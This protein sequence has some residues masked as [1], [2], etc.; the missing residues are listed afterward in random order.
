MKGSHLLPVFVAATTACA[1]MGGLRTAPLEAGDVTVYPDSLATV[2]A[3]AHQATLAAQLEVHDVTQTDSTTWMILASNGGSFVAG[4][5]ALVRVVIH[6]MSPGS[7]AVRIV[8]KKK[9]A[10]DLSTRTDWVYDILHHLNRALVRVPAG[11]YAVRSLPLGQVVR[12]NGSTLGTRVGPVAT[13][14]DSTLTLA[15]SVIRVAAID[16]LWVRGGGHAG[17]GGLV[18]GLVGLAA[19]IAIASGC[20][21][22]LSALNCRGAAVTVG[23]LGGGLIGLGIGAAI[24]HWRLRFP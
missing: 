10:T 4:Y 13:R 11:T 19:G 1:S 9:L 12:V 5:G 16:S 8:T 23:T 21:S 20:G 17:T 18:G 2:V 22:D 7:V 3:A 15:S 24:P 6:Q 14:T